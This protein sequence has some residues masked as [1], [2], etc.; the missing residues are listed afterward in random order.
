MVLL[1]DSIP[2]AVIMSPARPAGFS[3]SLWERVGVRGDLSTAPAR[4]DARPPGIAY[5]A[6]GG[7]ASSVPAP[8]LSGEG[9]RAAS[10]ALH[11]YLRIYWSQHHD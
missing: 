9:G 7:R 5:A 1:R 10:R 11:D 8:K 3:L 2:F 6:M 4:E